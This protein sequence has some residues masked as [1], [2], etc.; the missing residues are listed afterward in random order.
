MIV[1][2]CG[3]AGQG[4]SQVLSHLK[5][6]GYQVESLLPEPH[7]PKT[8]D[9]FC[10]QQN[11]L[12]MY[13]EKLIEEHN[14]SGNS[15]LLFIESSFIDMFVY[16]LLVVGISFDHK[17]WIDRYYQMCMESQRSVGLCINL[18]LNSIEDTSLPY[19][20][21]NSFNVLVKHYQGE[22]KDSCKIIDID[23]ESSDKSSEQYVE[24]VCQRVDE[25]I[26]KYG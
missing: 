1:N 23:V 24:K 11:N 9:E 15:E 19:F 17:D 18:P 14:K 3:A 21:A 2:L 5:E 26:E 10:K 22:I 4:K 8:I 7:C 20:T 12:L 13:R 25:V 16:S 6:E